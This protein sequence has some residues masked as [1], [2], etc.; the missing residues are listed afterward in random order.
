[1]SYYVVITFSSQHIFFVQ[2]FLF[3][4]I[5]NLRSSMKQELATLLHS[6]IIVKFFGYCL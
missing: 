2:V 6:E 3:I 1:M 5:T 4:L